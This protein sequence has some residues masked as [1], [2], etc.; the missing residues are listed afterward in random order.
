MH[1]VGVEHN[2]Y[3]PVLDLENTIIANGFINVFGFYAINDII[4]DQS[5]IP[6]FSQ[7]SCSA[8]SGPNLVTSTCEISTLTAMKNIVHMNADLWKT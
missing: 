7:L 2:K 6:A 4:T 3:E 5:E 1:P 8:I